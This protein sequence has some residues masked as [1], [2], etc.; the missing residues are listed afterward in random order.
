MI[1]VKNKFKTSSL[2]MAIVILVLTACN[3]D[4]EEIAGITPVV[5]SGLSIAETLAA[6]PDDSLFNKI[7]VK[8]GM[9]TALGNKSLTYT[10]FVLNND[11]MIASFGGPAIANFIIASLPPASCAGIVKY[12]MIP[13]KLTSAQII[14][15]FPNMQMPTDIVLDPTN[16]LV[17][18]TSFPSKNPSTNAY[19]FNNVPLT[20]VDMDVANGIIHHI[21]FL[22]PPPQKV[23]K[24]AL[25]TNTNLNYFRAAIAR[26]DSGQTGLNK[27]DSLLNYAVT[28]MT[29]LAPS[30][31]AFQTLIF[32]LAFQGYLSSRPMPYTATDTANAVAIANGAVAAGPV[33]LSTNN[34]STAL[35]RGVIAYHF[36]AT[37]N[38][39]T[40]AY[41]PNI[42]VFS[43]NFS[44]TP[45]FVT[46]LVNS[47]F[48]PHPGIMVNATFTGPFVT[49]LKFAGLGTFPP[50][51]APFSGTPATA[52]SLDNHAVNGAYY[53]IDHV[54]LPQ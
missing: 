45:S 27:F 43:V 29:V 23:L 2:L 13:Q 15:G 4:L 16:S 40:G 21:A 3:K 48:A 6:T 47:S 17:R 1:S 44:P 30:D 31:A 34:V 32:G 54:L 46:T 36:L 38:P 14:H 49:D 8:G 22:S 37:P 7:V 11:A 41:E 25:D 50:G 20:A 51:G 10:V 26:A 28:N 9:A 33:F 5:P 19:Y 18:M 24:G 39:S 52:I 35:V 53:V 12:L 42:R